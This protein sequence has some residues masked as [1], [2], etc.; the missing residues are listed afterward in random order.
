M[1]KG[2]TKMSTTKVI[3]R[4]TAGAVKRLNINLPARAYETLRALA[5]SSHRSM[6]DVVRIALSLVKVAMET[7]KDHNKLAVI[8]PE[9]KVLKEIVFVGGTENS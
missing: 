7:E 9:G 2:R 1:L 8:S 4:D 5:D 6:T 3:A